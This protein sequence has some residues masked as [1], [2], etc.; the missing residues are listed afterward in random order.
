MMT[1]T[2]VNKESQNGDAVGDVTDTMNS[3]T[4]V[5]PSIAGRVGRKK[6]K[7][8]V[9]TASQQHSKIGQN[10]DVNRSRVPDLEDTASDGVSQ[11]TS[12]I[13]KNDK[14]QLVKP[15]PVKSLR[16]IKRIF[17]V[18]DNNVSEK[19]E[20]VN[21]TGNVGE[22]L[23]NDDEIRSDRTTSDP[24][25]EISISGEELMHIL[26]TVSKRWAATAT[27]T[28]LREF[29][30]HEAL[31][32]KPYSYRSYVVNGVL[33]RRDDAKRIWRG[34]PVER[35]DPDGML[36]H[37]VDDDENYL[38]RAVQCSCNGPLTAD[39]YR[40]KDDFQSH[41]V[42]H[43]SPSEMIRRLNI[44]ERH[45][46]RIVKAGSEL[47]IAP[48]VN[49]TV[50]HDATPVDDDI[51]SEMAAERDAE[52][53]ELVEG[54]TVECEQAIKDWLQQM[55]KADTEFSKRC[56]ESARI[57]RKLENWRTENAAKRTLREVPSASG[58]DDSL[59]TESVKSVEDAH[60]PNDDLVPP[61]WHGRMVWPDF[62]HAF[63]NWNN[64][65]DLTESSQASYLRSAIAGVVENKLIET[66][67]PGQWTYGL[68][69]GALQNRCRRLCIGMK[70]VTP[71]VF[72]LGLL[73][74]EEAPDKGRTHWKQYTTKLFDWC[75]DQDLEVHER[76]YIL[77]RQFTKPSENEAEP[78]QSD[79]AENHVM[80]FAAI[81]QID[82][83][84]KRRRVYTDEQPSQQRT[85]LPKY[86]GEVNTWPTFFREFKDWC[87]K[88]QCGED[89]RAQYLRRALE[90]RVADEVMSEIGIDAL[91]YRPLITKLVRHSNGLGTPIKR[92]NQGNGIRRS[93][94]SHG[95]NR[96]PLF[97]GTNWTKFVRVFELV[98]KVAQIDAEAKAHY[99]RRALRGAAAAEV[100]T[101]IGV[102]WYTYEQLREELEFRFDGDVDY[103]KPYS[104]TARRLIRDVPRTGSASCS[105]DASLPKSSER[106]EASQHARPLHS[107][108]RRS[109]SPLCYQD[110]A[111]SSGRRSVTPPG[112]GIEDSVDKD[113]QHIAHLLRRNHILLEQ[114]SAL[115][116]ERRDCCC[117]KRDFFAPRP[118]A[119]KPRGQY[120]RPKPRV[121]KIGGF[122][123]R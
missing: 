83:G 123:G 96:L 36:R 3:N 77:W 76:N 2:D 112:Y 57:L 82:A 118:P 107:V 81:R 55:R 18:L 6:K 7:V 120:G 66:L 52:L 48:Q 62:W 111:G 79:E 5:F 73:R 85:R 93:G 102:D 117:P 86:D 90:G 64:Q 122:M 87:D 11:F 34:Q 84:N 23:S 20:G 45:I 100:H 119:I 69:V 8:K 91:R 105:T 99:L 22:S 44:H 43:G 54:N 17:N 60:D 1:R 63:R 101:I 41:M 28:E 46:E 50:K 94:I 12:I 121:S 26:G 74:D 42:T 13:E 89:A 115:S 51:S 98:C 21:V 59:E 27:Q 67:G 116:R 10:G 38:Q 40:F 97:N 15:L 114:N 49:P 109:A 31:Y 106:A 33:I 104:D 61:K 4:D 103:L 35:F 95:I 80:A 72:A 88:R 9:A 92:D 68:T 78:I 25:S 113:Q 71:R 47:K 70:E 65:C 30:T 16:K 24:G 14:V 56:V 110:T 19:S 53:E 29:A 37:R 58:H 32:E 108:E 39:E 75:D